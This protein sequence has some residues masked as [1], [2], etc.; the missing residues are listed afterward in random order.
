MTPQETSID[1]FAILSFRTKEDLTL[2][3]QHTNADRPE[4]SSTLASDDK[5]TRPRRMYVTTKRRTKAHFNRALEDSRGDM[6]TTIG[7]LETSG[8]DALGSGSD[9]RNGCSTNGLCIVDVQSDRSLDA[10]IKFPVPDSDSENHGRST[11]LDASSA[12]QLTP[13]RISKY[14][15]STSPG[16]NR[17]ATF[18]S[19][20]HDE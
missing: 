11:Q 20:S 2:Y 4:A 19:I 17:D 13:F 9:H 1:G 12:S 15:Q 6:L 7:G 18:E 8:E 3:M 14:W 10:C 16:A 5:T